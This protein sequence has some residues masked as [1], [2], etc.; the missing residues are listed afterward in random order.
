MAGEFT[1]LTNFA[2]DKEFG[3]VASQHMLYDRKPKPRAALVAATALVDTEEALS[4]ARNEFWIDTFA[5]I[6]DNEV[7]TQ[8]NDGATE[9]HE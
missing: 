4:Q 7:G 9:V 1:A 2:R 8:V 3:I 5:G 6:G